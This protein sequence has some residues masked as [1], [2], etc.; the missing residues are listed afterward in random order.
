MRKLNFV[1]AHTLFTKS[2]VAHME[3]REFAARKESPGEGED[4]D[5]ITFKG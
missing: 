2:V 4:V 1:V 3:D 5:C